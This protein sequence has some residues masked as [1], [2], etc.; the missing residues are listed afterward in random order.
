M[1]VSASTSHCPESEEFMLA[2]GEAEG[3]VAVA[4]SGELDVGPL[5]A[6]GRAA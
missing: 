1:R 6:D 4:P 2:H 5:L 3:E